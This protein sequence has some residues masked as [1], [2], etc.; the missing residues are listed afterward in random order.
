M[1]HIEQAFATK[2]LRYEFAICNPV[3]QYD[4]ASYGLCRRYLI[5]RLYRDNERA[6][7][8]FLQVFTTNRAYN[9]ALHGYRFKMAVVLESR[10]FGSSESYPSGVDNND[11]SH[12]N[13]LNPNGDPTL[14]PSDTPSPS[15]T[16]LAPTTPPALQ[17]SSPNDSSHAASRKS[18]SRMKAVPKPVREV[19]KN[20]E[21]KY[22]CNWPDCTEPAREFARKCEWSKHMD[23]HER[24]YKCQAQGCEKLP[25]FTYAGGL[26]RHGREVH[27]QHGGPKNPLFCPHANCKR[28]NGKE[29]ARLENLNE[30]L[31][32][33]HT[34]PNTGSGSPAVTPADSGQPV[35]SP[36][37]LR[38]MSPQIGDKRKADDD[39][40]IREEVKRLRAENVGLK[41]QQMAMMSQLD[42]H[43]REINDLQA[44]LQTYRSSNIPS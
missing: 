41:S 16:S 15:A 39:E 31:R 22:I 18:S 32:R 40:D 14:I 35:M 42:E 23:K 29:F 26:L 17:A 12:F 1:Q 44:Q 27:N 19:V 37:P 13:P 10:R 9:R 7:L 3:D 43:R 21:G 38:P 33:C 25:G 20:R 2:S 5:P 24:P 6:R 36:P 4:L 30:H 34:D 28:Y 8:E 11:I